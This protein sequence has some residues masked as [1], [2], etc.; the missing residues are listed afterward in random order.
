MRSPKQRPARAADAA[1]GAA[2]TPG[3]LRLHARADSWI[4]V[5]DARGQSLLSRTVRGGETVDL[6]GAAPMR[7][8]IGN[9]R[10]TEIVFRGRAL[11]LAPFTRD[12]LA[13]LELK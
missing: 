11:E 13:R 9:A 6:D 8:K 3:V 4:E 1:S 12:N 10:D 2:T 5:L 7:L